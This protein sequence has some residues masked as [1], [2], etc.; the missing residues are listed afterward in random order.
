LDP[1]RRRQSAIVQVIGIVDENDPAIQLRAEGVIGN[2]AV[3]GVVLHLGCGWK[4]DGEAAFLGN[5]GLA[6]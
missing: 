5:E 2:F 3:D 4:R 1:L 6:A